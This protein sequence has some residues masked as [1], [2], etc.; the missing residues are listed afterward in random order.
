MG[1]ISRATVSTAALAITT[2]TWCSKPRGWRGTGIASA[3]FY[4]PKAKA[5]PRRQPSKGAPAS[6]QFIALRSS[7]HMPASTAAVSRAAAALQAPCEP[8]HYCIDGVRLPCPPG[9]FGDSPGLSTPSCSGP[10]AAGDMSTR[11][12]S[13]GS[14]CSIHKYIVQSPVRDVPSGPGTLRALAPRKRLRELIHCLLTRPHGLRARL[15]R[16]SGT[17]HRVPLRGRIEDSDGDRVRRR[18]R[19][20]LSGR[21]LFP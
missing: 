2:S 7:K 10:C 6:Q 15:W 8:G 19:P 4:L 16:K 13:G 9:F 14:L 11:A 18:G 5:V 20:V 1:G 17:T 3:L 12:N 21:F